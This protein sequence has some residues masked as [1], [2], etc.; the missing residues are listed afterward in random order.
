MTLMRI[1]GKSC[2]SHSCIKFVVIIQPTKLDGF[3]HFLFASIILL[4]NDFKLD[5]FRRIIHV[6]A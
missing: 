6:T 2:G 4:P 1:N 3:E 5:I